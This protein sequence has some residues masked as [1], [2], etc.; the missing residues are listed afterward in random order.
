MTIG[1]TLETVRALKDGYD[2]DDET[3]LSYINAVEHMILNDIVRGREGDETV[4]ER[5]SGCDLQ[6]DRNTELFAPPPYDDI[7]A[8]YCAAQVDLLAEDGERY[9]NDAAVFRDMFLELKKHWWR[10]HRQVRRFSYHG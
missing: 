2:V 1:K 6:T 7:Y 5:Y 8:R 9:L 4:L 3:L 10:T